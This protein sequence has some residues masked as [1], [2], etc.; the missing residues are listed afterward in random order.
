MADQPSVH[1]E[2]YL[3]ES[4]QPLLR[5]IIILFIIVSTVAFLLRLASRR[6][7]H[8]KWQLDD[9]LVTLGWLTSNAFMGLTLANMTYGGLGLHQASL[10][11]STLR[12]S[13]KLLLPSSLLYTY[14]VNLPKLAIVA[15]YLSFFPNHRPTKIICYA[16]ALTLCLSMIANTA[17]GLAIC[18]PLHALWDGGVAEHC[19]DVNAWLRYGRVVNFVSGV[20]ML[21]LPAAHVVRLELEPGRW[22]AVAIPFLVGSFG[23]AASIISFIRIPTANAETDGTYSATRVF[24]WSTVEIGMYHLAACMIAYLPLG[25]WIM[26]KIHREPDDVERKEP[27]FVPRRRVD[28]CPPLRDYGAREMDMEMEFAHDMGAAY[29]LSPGGQGEM[30][31]IRIGRRVYVE[32][33]GWI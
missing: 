6:I 15:V 12:T 14:A 9:T 4:R 1:S 32:P 11:P 33:A 2:K 16:T 23:L 25:K 18:R 5:A 20:V 8:V 21:V 10:P 13:A 31:V 24:L 3:F 28:I 26:S 17:A 27:T 19:S 22:V 30:G 7:G 29:S